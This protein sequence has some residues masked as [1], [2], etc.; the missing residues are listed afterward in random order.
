MGTNDEDHGTD[1][2]H[3][4]K[5]TDVSEKEGRGE[6]RHENNDYEKG[7]HE[8]SESWRHVAMP[9]GPFLAL[10]SLEALFLNSWL[11]EIIYKIY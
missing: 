4:K 3:T 11:I 10:A 7:D 8:M 9:F 2:H 1:A 6:G 5:A